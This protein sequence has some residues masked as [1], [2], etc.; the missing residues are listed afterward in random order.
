MPYCA[1][2]CAGGNITIVKGLV[3]ALNHCAKL[4]GHPGGRKL[5][6]TLRIYFYWPTMGFDCYAVAKNCAAC[7]RERVKWGK[8]EGNVV[9]HTQ[10]SAGVCRDRHPRRTN[11]NQTRKSL[12]LRDQRSIL[13]VGTDRTLQEN[14]CGAY[15]ASVRA[16]LGIRIWTTRET[17][18]RQWNAVH[19][20]VLSEHL[21]NFGD[22]ERLHDDVSSAGQGPS[23]EI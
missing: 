5:Y 1:R 2:V 14:H 8:Y 19:D 7:A 6:K 3:L 23:R 10:R 11:Y 20:P 15:R 21:P 4:E 12:Y 13:E 9:V 16:T 22:T 18:V 17:A